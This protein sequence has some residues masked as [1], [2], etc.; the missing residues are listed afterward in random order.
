MRRTQ[1]LALVAAWGTWDARGW[2]RLFC[3][4]ITLAS[5]LQLAVAGGV[6]LLAWGMN[7]AG[8]TNI[9]PAATNLVAVGAGW[10]HGLALRAD[11]TLVPW[12]YAGDNLTVIPPEATNIV[13]VAVG[14]YHSLALRADGRVF[15][16]GKNEAGESTVP[17]DATNIVALDGGYSHTLALRADGTVLAWGDNTFG[18]RDIPVAATDVVAIAAGMDHNVA[19]KADGSVVVWGINQSGET[20]L[21][22]SATNVVAISAGATHSLALR[23]DGAIVP[24][25]STVFGETTVPVNVTNVKAISSGGW[26]NLVVLQNGNATGWGYDF[27]HQATPPSAVANPAALYA[28]GEFSIAW[29]RDAS[30]GIAP[31]FWKQPPDRAFAGGQT[32]YLHPGVNGTP[33]LR[34]RWHFNNT[35]LPGQTH[36]WLALPNANPAQ[37][38]NYFLVVSNDFGATT[39]RVAAVTVQSIQFISQPTN[40]TVMMNKDVTLTATVAGTAPLAYRW[41]KDGQPL[42]DTARL[43][44]SDTPT[45]TNQWVLGAD[46]GNYQLAVSNASS[47]VTSQVAQVTV[48]TP[49]PLLNVDFN[50]G[51]VSAKTGLAGM[52]QTDTD[53][54]NGHPGGSSSISNLFLADG[55]QSAI[56]VTITNSLFSRWIEYDDPMLHNFIYPPGFGGSFTVQISGLPAGTYSFYLYNAGTKYWPWFGSDFELIVGG[57]SL[58]HKVLTGWIENPPPWREDVDYGTIHNVQVT[59]TQQSVA[60]VVRGNFGQDANLA[61]MQIGGFL[62][63]NTPP[64]F[65]SQPASQFVPIGTNIVLT[66]TGNGFPS[67]AQQWFFNDV[68]L[69][70]SARITG[71][72]TNRLVVTGAEFM[73]AGNYYAVLTNASGVI[74]SA[75]AA[76]VVGIPPGLSAPPTN[77]TWI[78]G[79]TS[80]LFAGATG[81]EPLT[82]RWYLGATVLTNSSRI[83]GGDSNILTVSN[84]LTSDAG[85]YTLVVTNPFGSITSTAIVAV[86][87]PPAFTRQPAGA[88]VPVGMPL[89]LSAA[90][91]GTAPLNYQWRFNG[92]NVPGANT[93]SLNFAGLNP[94]D[95]GDYQL[96]VSNYGGVITSATAQVTVGAVAIWGT[97]GI[98]TLP[99]WPGP[100]LSNVIAVAGGAG[101]SLALRADGTVYAW[102]SGTST[103]VPAGLSDVVAI[104]AGVHAMAVRA[105]GA[106]TAWGIGSSGQTNIPPGLSNVI[107]VA[108]GDTHSAALRRDGTVVVWGGST[109]QKQTNLPAG[110]MHVAA[111]RAGGS[112]TLALREN[113]DVV[114]WGGAT[115][116]PVP[117][118]LHGVAQVSAPA[119]LLP[120]SGFALALL[121]NGTVTAWD[122]S[123]WPTNMFPGISNVMAVEAAGGSR[124]QDIG[125]INNASMILQT[126][127]LVS[128]WAM[129]ASP[130][131]NVPPG[132][133][134]AVAIAGGYTHMLALLNTGKPL[135]VGPPTGGTFYTGAELRLKA[136]AEGRPP[137]SFQ[138]HRN[139]APVPSATNVTF[140]IA[141]VQGTDA[142]SYHLV[143]TNELG[144]AQ[145]IAI[146]VTVVD[147]TPVLMSQPASRYAWFGSPLN[148]GSSVIGS[149]PMQLTWFQNGSPVA[150]DTKELLFERALPQHGGA[151]QLIASN[152]FGSVTSSVATITFSKVAT[153]GGAP[154]LT[155]APVDLGNVLAVASGYTHALAIRSD[156]T[157]AAWGTTA[158]GVTNVPVGLSDVVAISGGNNFSVALKSDGTVAAWGLGTSGQTNVPVSLTNVVA[159]SAGGSHALALRANGT[160][161]AW[162]PTL[163]GVTNMPAGLSNVVAIAA[164]STHSLALKDD[165]TVVPWGTYGTPPI[166][167]NIVAISAGY[168]HSLALQANGTVLAWTSAKAPGPPAGLS[169]VVAI[170]AGG[171][172]SGSSLDVALRADGTLVAWGDNNSLGQTIVPA[173][174]WSAT[175]ISAGGSSTLALLN[176]RSPAITLQP[177]SRRVAS[178]T[179]LALGALAVGRPGLSYQW[180]RDGEFVPDAT[181]NWLA[182]T[183]TH[184]AH[185]GDYQLVAMND[186]GATTSA[187]ATVTVSI[188]QPV[189]LSPGTMTNGFRFS[190]LSIAGVIY[191]VEYKHNLSAGAWTELERRFGVGGVEIVTD[192]SANSAMRFYR[193]RALYAPSPKLG[194]ATWNGGSVNFNFATVAGAQYIVEFTDQLASPQWHEVQTISGTGSSVTFTNSAQAAPQR[195]FRLRVR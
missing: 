98:S 94:D 112:Q 136:A 125:V 140:S 73:D 175:A 32:L 41:L 173:D 103:N 141:A 29:L 70:N 172:Y 191:V 170:S 186:F 5:T 139:G 117:P 163:Y 79:S 37:S 10:Q 189:L 193:V 122:S 57:A 59:G 14:D 169:N 81:T 161:A 77:Q 110:L 166:L 65:W 176:D 134:N 49:A 92:T 84:V 179:N 74:T 165:G 128:G 177:W 111:I 36:S 50:G 118:Y 174:L 27:N 132:V 13:A 187:V 148:F 71:A 116:F 105:N 182:F 143:V 121:T 66:A 40:V 181:N 162:G 184:P 26:F 7:S 44:G 69:T 3:L 164:G 145:S 168:N 195:F 130:L 67:P 62:T 11:G 63:S 144:A 153:W 154:G 53:F 58:G 131:T 126:N 149:G 88:S 43:S 28:G 91:S 52:G 80:S 106:V 76:I 33:P 64:V 72:Q 86:V 150:S 15:A 9:P 12:G 120:S 96:V 46:S 99:I 156:R 192:T 114:G 56:S 23:A 194:A 152:S 45:L 151:Y 100:G 51:L 34:Y 31:T 133:S 18:Q 137:L 48:R 39:S 38:G 123:G 129:A 55:S 190:F 83:S 47:V 42:S 19:L 1:Q 54:W 90:V 68:P 180:Y 155:N 21:P 85:T 124:G 60:L 6:P 16:W 146:P 107:S 185:S 113:G 22:P 135:I 171:G 8:Q 97:Y 30:N 109:S 167:T 138:W 24:W 4:L 115:P 61:G 75:T 95:F 127:G 35:P 108:A 157:V 82:Y 20:N 160:V 178:G 102:G 93:N 101:F 78:A 17:A 188:P 2:R 142:G 87:V 158:N 183:P 119:P 159:V 89:T 147:S 25:G 104:S